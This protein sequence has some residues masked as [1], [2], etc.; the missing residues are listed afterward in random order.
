MATKEDF[1]NLTWEEYDKI[2][3]E[4]GKKIKEYCSKNAY[5]ISYIVPILRGGGFLGIQ[6]SHILN[7]IRIIPCQYKYMLID[8]NYVPIELLE[9]RDDMESKDRKSCILVTEG[10]HCSGATAQKCIQKVR[11]LY[12][13]MNIIYA[14][15]VRDASHLNKME[16]TI[17]EVYGVLSNESR[18][19]SSN[20]CEENGI[21]DKF[22]IFPW[23]SIEEELE[24][25]NNSADNYLE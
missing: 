25:V 12:P 6:L 15:L 2:V 21:F 7:V 1:Y 14:S 9:I 20:Y 23:E 16:G 3:I 8:N 22:S 17:F 19:L 5:T 11:G 13:Q 4:L 18:K 10:N 24:E